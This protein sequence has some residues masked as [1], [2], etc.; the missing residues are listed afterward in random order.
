MSHPAWYYIVSFL[1]AFAIVYFSVP[2]IRQLALR[3]GF[4]DRPNQRKI[5][6][7]PVPLLGGLALYVSFVASSAL[8][9]HAGKAFWGIAAGGLLIFTIGVVDDYYK[10]RGRDLKAWPKFVMQILAA[11]V[12]VSFGVSIGGVTLPLQG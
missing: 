2:Y 11:V 10:T 7:E 8:F 1:V 9:G 6:K 12:L 5:H 4:V 3:T